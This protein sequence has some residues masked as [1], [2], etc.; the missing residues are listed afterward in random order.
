MC[1]RC[2]VFV[3]LLRS[4]IVAKL[5]GLVELSDNENDPV[6]IDAEEKEVPEGTSGEVQPA[7][8]AG[9]DAEEMG[10][11]H[12]KRPPL[13]E[14]PPMPELDDDTRQKL[15]VQMPVPV[16]QPTKARSKTKTKGAAKAKAEPKA[17]AAAKRKA[18]AKAKKGKEEAELGEDAVGVPRPGLVA[19]VVCCLL[20]TLR[21]LKVLCARKKARKASASGSAAVGDADGAPPDAECAGDANKNLT[22]AVASLPVDAQPAAELLMQGR[23]NFTKTHPNSK[24]RI[25]IQ[26]PSRI[27]SLYMDNLCGS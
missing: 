27:P 22:V 26:C 2:F 4:T 1:L 23:K 11:Q 3:G 6:V 17:K 10:G 7:P 18:K 9:S 25:Q 20:S 13:L 12:F 16:D 14:I 8:C 24:I 5:K 21:V 19:V 15:R